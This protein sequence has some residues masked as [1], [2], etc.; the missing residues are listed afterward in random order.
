MD[1]VDEHA[2]ADEGEGETHRDGELRHERL[3]AGADAPQ[4]HERVERARHEHGEHELVS[5]V[6]H[7][8]LHESRTV[9]RG[10][11]RQDGDRDG[12]HRRRGRQHRGRDRG[13]QTPRS[14]RSHAEQRQPVPARRQVDRHER[15]SEREGERDEHGGDEPE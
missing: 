15:L 3:R 14:V 11:E 8:V 9:R 12:E 2:H 4:H 7:E 5:S 13:E 6:C 10:G 1:E